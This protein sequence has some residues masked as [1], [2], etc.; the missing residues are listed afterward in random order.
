MPDILWQNNATGER[1][2]W[3]MNGTTRMSSV[4]LP[5]A[6]TQ[7]S[8]AGAADFNNDGNDDIL[9]QNR[10]TGARVVWLMH[11]YT[12]MSGVSLGIVSTQW[13]IVASSDFSGDGRPDIVFPERKVAVFCDGDFWHGNQ[14]RR[15]GFLA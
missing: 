9:W 1:A 4:S 10:T 15:R 11:G 8:L 7:W 14:W 3:L 6:S 13:N 5:S 2:I 12:L